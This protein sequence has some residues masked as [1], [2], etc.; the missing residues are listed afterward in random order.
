M[1]SSDE[2]DEC[3]VVYDIS[4]VEPVPQMR[5]NHRKN[6]I[7]VKEGWKDTGCSEEQSPGGRSHRDPTP[8]GWRD[9]SAS[10]AGRIADRSDRIDPISPGGRGGVRAVVVRGGGGGRDSAGTNSPGSESL[11]SSRSSLGLQSNSGSNSLLTGLFN[12]KGQAIDLVLEESQ[13]SWT[14][15]GDN[16]P[17]KKSKNEFKFVIELHGVYCARIRR[18]KSPQQRH[19]VGGATRSD[20][21]A[22]G[23]CQGFEIYTYRAKNNKLHTK[24]WFFQHPSTDLCLKFISRIHSYIEG[25]KNRP[26]KIKL[27]LQPHA[28]NKE[29]ASLYTKFVGPILNLAGVEVDYVEVYHNEAIKQK[30]LHTD[31]D[32]YDCLAVMGGDGSAKKLI[33]AVLNKTQSENHVEIKP[34]FKPVSNQIPIAIIPC[35]ITNNIVTSV[36]GINNVITATLNMVLGY[37]MNIDVNSIFSMDKFIGWSLNSHYGFY[38]N[39]Q[40]HRSTFTHRRGRQLELSYLKSLSTRRFRSYDCNIKYVPSPNEEKSHPKDGKIC[41]YNCSTCDRGNKDSVDDDSPEQD[42]L[43]EFDPLAESGSS[44]IITDLRNGDVEQDWKKLQGPYIN[45]S[46]MSNPGR[47]Q[48]APRGFS[49]YAHL[50]DGYMDLIVVTSTDRKSF[51]R[52]LKRHGNYKNQFEYPF[53]EVHRV[54][55]VKFKQQLKSTWHQKDNG[56]N[57]EIEQQMANVKLKRTLKKSASMDVIDT[58]RLSDDDSDDE[59]DGDDD[60]SSIGTT[61]TGANSENTSINGDNEKDDEKP[62][63]RKRRLSLSSLFKGGLRS[64]RS[65][66]PAAPP[67]GPA[68]SKPPPSSSKPRS[69]IAL[70]ERNSVKRKLKRERKE[71]KRK[72]KEESRSRSNWCVDNEIL[73]DTFTELHF[74][75]QPRL[76][77]ITGDGVHDINVADDNVRYLFLSQ[78]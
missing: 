45:V 44:S 32:E 49:K 60:S 10:P 12:F 4:G 13:L 28:G 9:D 65:S 39:V 50:A 73:D 2:F 77:K 14:D 42:E 15:A 22:E 62:T 63:L 41:H 43:I 27:F 52:F 17:V 6:R 66:T 64:R 23:A 29:A 51:L 71:Q 75:V 67:A 58:D 31:F 70:L 36:Q 25:L 26:K 24:I 76:L 1:D 5:K 37:S 33:N 21:T 3:D 47:C 11:A 54:K 48:M 59:E 61:T 78:I 57:D 8:R 72:E 18:L 16:I 34:G 40:S 74:T 56:Y 69:S 53:V 7:T 55:E 38:G 68:S 30:V 20:P 35:G 46:I 19:Q